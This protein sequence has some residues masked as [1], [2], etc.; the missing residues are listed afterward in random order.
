MGDEEPAAE[1]AAAEPEVV[2]SPRP[3]PAEE[4]AVTAAEIGAWC[5]MSSAAAP[6]WLLRSANSTSSGRGPKPKH[7]DSRPWRALARY[8]FLSQPG[9]RV[10]AF[11]S[12]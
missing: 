8:V 5:G 7:A 11:L 10:A 1:P 9:L 2:V 4:G 3:V 6:P 12:L